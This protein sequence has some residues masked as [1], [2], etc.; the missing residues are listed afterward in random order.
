[1][2]V[3]APSLVYL[4]CANDNGRR[5]EMIALPPLL[6]TANVPSV[7][8]V[9]AQLHD[10]PDPV[11]C[12]ASHLLVAEPMALCALATTLTRMQRPGRDVQVIGL[13]PQLKQQLE[14]LDIISH[15]LHL[16]T[17]DRAIG[18]KGILHAY[19]VSNERQGNEIANLI[20]NSIAELIP[21][22][23]AAFDE[24]EES[25][26]SGR[27]VPPLSYLFT[28]LIDNG[29]RHGRGRGYQ[30]A[31][32]WLSAQ[33]HPPRGLIRFAVA[34]DGC[35]FLA[36]FTDREDIKA[37]T[38]GDAIRAGFRPFTSSKRDVGLF[39]DAPHL[40]LGLTICRDLARRSDGSVSVVSGSSWITNPGLHTEHSEVAPF[41]QGAVVSVELRLPAL[42]TL[43]FYEIA[44]RYHPTPDLPL[45]LM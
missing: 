36:T 14:R 44:R 6:I 37:K 40:G 27:L 12:D 15:S 42:N 4:L 34:D 23:R 20:A 41:W 9:C 30:H 45:R 1:M 11:V 31:T 29:F 35:G 24:F 33:Y 13:S 16:A 7:F 25:N 5:R 32:V 18:Y 8:R 2:T 21:P 38:H 3:L 19:H 28:E 22:Q 39:N 26:G 10:S 17:N 43:N